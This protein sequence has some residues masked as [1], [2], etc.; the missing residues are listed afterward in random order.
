VTT[1]AVNRKMMACDSKVTFGNEFAT[2]SDKV[3][4]I[5]NELLGCAGD[6]A[7][8]LKFLEWFKTKGD[9]PE[10]DDSEKWEIVLLNKSG[11]YLYINSFACFRICDPIYTAGS[12]GM[13]ARAAM[14][15]GKSPTEAVRIAIKCDNSSGGPVRTFQLADTKDA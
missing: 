2:C 1:I 3:V 15:C 4:R 6:T 7:A 8:I 14:L 12:G 10:M 5:G 9:Q 11:I 13:A